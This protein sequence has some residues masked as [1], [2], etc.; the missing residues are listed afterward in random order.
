MLKKPLTKLVQGGANRNHIRPQA[1]S[2]LKAIA[3]ER[4]HRYQIAL[5]GDQESQSIAYFAIVM[6]YQY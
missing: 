3:R 6:N 1:L 4:S 2:K 5:T